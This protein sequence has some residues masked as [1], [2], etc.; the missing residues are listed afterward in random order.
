MQPKYVI[1]VA[2]MEDG[3]VAVQGPIQD[4]ILALGLLELGKQAVINHNQAKRP[5]L[6]VPQ[7]GI[8]IARNGRV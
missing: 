6:L 2:V 3:Q 1:S 7:Q 4:K 5:G 8:E